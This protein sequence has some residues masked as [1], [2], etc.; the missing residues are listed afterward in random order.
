[1]ENGE[2]EIDDG[3]QPCSSKAGNDGTNQA[4][5]T[6]KGKDKEDGNEEKVTKEQTVSFFPIF[7][8][9]FVFLILF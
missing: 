8:D 3:Q 4:K 7:L 5:R 1:M 6:N 9:D 2:E